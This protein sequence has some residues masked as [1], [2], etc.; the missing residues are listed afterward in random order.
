M[1]LLFFFPT[2]GLYHNSS[3]KVCDAA[4]SSLK[5]TRAHGPSHSWRQRATVGKENT[6]YYYFPP[7]AV[8]LRLPHSRPAP[9]R[10]SASDYVWSS[11]SL[12]ATFQTHGSHFFSSKLAPIQKELHC[13]LS[14]PLLIALMAA[15]ST[16]WYSCSICYM[17]FFSC[18]YHCN[19][20][21]SSHN[22]DSIFRALQLPKDMRSTVP[23]TRLN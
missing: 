1:Q 22:R 10:Q 13:S 16:Q 17:E 19:A 21:C 2:A 11:S 14:K 23:L 15:T 18:H 3:P 4:F 12:P 5:L 20:I 8:C 7:R 6:A 9:K